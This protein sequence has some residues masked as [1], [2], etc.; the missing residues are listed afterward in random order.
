MRMYLYRPILGSPHFWQTDKA[1]VD[2]ST[3]HQQRQNW[4]VAGVDNTGATVYGLS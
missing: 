3:I 1:L 2:W 4:R